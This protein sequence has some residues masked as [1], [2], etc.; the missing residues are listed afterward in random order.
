MPEREMERWGII[1]SPKS[2]VRH[3]HRRWEEIRQCLGE[4]GV[5][6][7]F[8][9]SEGG[10]SERRLAAMLANNGYTYIII[11][12]GDRAL[13]HAING[14]ASLGDEA[15]EAV[16]LGVIPSGNVN[17]FASFWG[18]CED[19]PGRSVDAL[20]RGRVRRVDLGVIEWDEGRHYFLNCVNIGLVANI[21]DL[22]H[23]TYRFWGMSGLSY[24]SSM[25]LLLFQRME[26]RMR[27]AINHERVDERL[28]SVCIGNSRGYGQTPNAVPYNGMLDVSL[29][30]YPAVTQ[31]FVGMS[32]MLTGRFLS[33]RNVRPFR[34]RRSVRVEDVGNARVSADGLVLTGLKAPFRVS[35]R[36]EAVNFLIP[37]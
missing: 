21:A 29:I 1:Y 28:V 14:V 22:R 2:G 34:T 31:L 5:D 37:A 24:L 9:Q 23:K 17:D 15:L 33:S 12:G 3:T 35:V 20:R 30:S 13:N 11:V 19:D 25:F 6:Y 36:K 4:R 7:D 27:L 32:L 18:L 10:G 8:V 16:R 26:T